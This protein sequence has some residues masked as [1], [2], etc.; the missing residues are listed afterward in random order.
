MLLS[1]NVLNLEMQLSSTWE[2]EPG[3]NLPDGMKNPPSLA[4]RGGLFFMDRQNILVYYGDASG[5]G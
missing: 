2:I 5:D 3:A 4:V 1:S